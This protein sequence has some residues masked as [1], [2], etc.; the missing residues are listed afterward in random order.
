MDDLVYVSANG[1]LR[2]ANTLIL[3]FNV[4]GVGRCVRGS[5]EMFRDIMQVLKKYDPE[6][7]EDTEIEVKY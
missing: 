2:V 6:L 3:G 5:D 4:N 1:E 7:C